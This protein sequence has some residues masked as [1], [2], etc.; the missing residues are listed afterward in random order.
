[1]ICLK[2]ILNKK[3]FS[4]AVLIQ[5]NLIYYLQSWFPGLLL[6]MLQRYVMVR[7]RREEVVEMLNVNNEE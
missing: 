4:L 6:R 7:A 1:M 5:L 2:C 3:C